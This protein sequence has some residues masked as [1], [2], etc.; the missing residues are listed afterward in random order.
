MK[1]QIRNIPFLLL[2]ALLLAACGEDDILQSSTTGAEGDDGAVTYTFTA[3]LDA[4]MQ[5]D[6]PGTRATATTEDAPTRCFM[7]A[8]RQD[9]ASDF[10]FVAGTVNAD[11]TITFEIKLHPEKEYTYLF[12]ADNGSETVSNLT[13][14]PYTGG[15][16]AYAQHVAAACTPDKLT[17]P[18][19]THVVA[20]LTVKTSKAVGTTYGKDISLTASCAGTYNVSTSAASD[21]SD[22]SV[23]MTMVDGGIAADAE[24]LTTYLI[25]NPGNK[26]VT[27]KAHSMDMTIADVP[28][29]IN[30]HVTLKGDLST[31]GSQWKNAPDA[32]VDE[33]LESY[34]FDDSGKP[35]GYNDTGDTYHFHNATEEDILAFMK[36]LTRDDSF[37]LPASYFD[38]NETIYI[39]DNIMLRNYSQLEHIY[40]R[41]RFIYNSTYF[42]IYMHCGSYD[43]KY[44]DFSTLYPGTN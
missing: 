41:L 37:K 22:N 29:A 24:V 32:L 28:L 40:Y 9:N 38:N 14:V 18:T 44:A 3:S 26:A 11:K 5:G 4:S 13:A 10:E 12:W 25:P 16:V 39:T 23:S 27:L 30:T 34:F 21:Y 20:K 19:L 8:I 15:S 33:T 31:S 6:A 42:I 1:I 2:F 36:S 17:I 43:S 7:Q 35:K